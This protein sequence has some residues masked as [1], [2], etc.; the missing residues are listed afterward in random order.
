MIEIR[1]ARSN[2]GDRID[3]LI[4]DQLPGHSN[5]SVVQ[6]LELERLADTEPARPTLSL[7]PCAAEQLMDQLWDC[8]LR[9]S[10]G[11]GSAGAMAATQLHLADMRRAYEAMLVRLQSLDHRDSGFSGQ[12]EEALLGFLRQ[13]S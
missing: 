7:Q 8:G 12:L 1:A 4:L 6:K 13:R 2:W 5:F 3:M 11:S 9:P 10:E